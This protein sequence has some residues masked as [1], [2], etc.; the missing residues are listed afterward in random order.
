MDALKLEILTPS[1]IQAWKN[2]AIKA[3]GKG[4]VK[5]RKA[6]KTVNST[7]LNV[8]S[9]FAKKH[10]RFVKER[11]TLPD[12]LPFDEVT[13]EKRQSS[14]YQS[15]IDAPALIAATQEELASRTEEQKILFLALTCGLRKAEIDGLE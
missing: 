1:A 6:K 7:I 10:L 11:L 4:P 3:A 9:I 14:R 8:R 2:D 15:K 5:Q 12:P 13:L